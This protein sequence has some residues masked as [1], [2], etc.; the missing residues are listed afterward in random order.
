MVQLDSDVE[1]VLR[2]MQERI[3]VDRLV[4]VSRLIAAAAPLFWG[5]DAIASLTVPAISPYAEHTQLVSSECHRGRGC[6]GDG[7]AGEEVGLR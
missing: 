5:D 6:V 4:L 7:F 2:L 3:P 1:D